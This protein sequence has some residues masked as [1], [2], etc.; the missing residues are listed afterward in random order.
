MSG[1]RAASAALARLTSGAR[2]SRRSEAACI[3]ALLM[4][5]SGDGMV[6]SQ[7]GISLS[8][9][10]VRPIDPIS[11]TPTLQAMAL[12]IDVS[13]MIIASVSSFKAY[14]HR[15]CVHIHFSAAST[16]KAKPPNPPY[17]APRLGWGMQTIVHPSR[18]RKR[19]RRFR[20][21]G[22]SSTSNRCVNPWWYSRILSPRSLSLFSSTTPGPTG[23]RMALSAGRDVMNTPGRAQRRGCGHRPRLQD[24]P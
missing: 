12:I 8:R 6:D 10:L 9:L 19:R 14:A 5:T 4:R 17:P 3:T 24:N 16:P 7:C 13:R 22:E 21:R 1:R 20:S 18:P 11:P 23:I 15:V 2:S